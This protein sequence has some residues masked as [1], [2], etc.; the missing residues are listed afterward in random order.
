[1]VVATLKTFGIPV[2]QLLQICENDFIILW[3]HVLQDQKLAQRTKRFIQST[4]KW[5]ILCSYTFLILIFFDNTKLYK[6][7]GFIN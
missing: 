6:C 4:R 2:E 3:L 7:E 5:K 1:M